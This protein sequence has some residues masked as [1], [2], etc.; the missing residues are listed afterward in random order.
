MKKIV[1]ALSCCAK[2]SAHLKILL[3]WGNS[4]KWE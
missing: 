2:I 4:P 1:A 3:K